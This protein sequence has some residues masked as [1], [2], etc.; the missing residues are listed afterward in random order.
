MRARLDDQP[1]N[2]PASGWEYVDDETIRLLPAGTP[3][4]QSHVYEFSLHRQGSAWWR[5]S[6]SP[7]RAISSRFLR[8]ALKDDAGNPNPLAGDVRH[9]FSFSIS[10]PS[11][12]L[13]DFQAF[14]FNEDEA[15]KT[16]HRRHAQ[17]DRRRQRRSNQLSVRADRQNRAEP[18]EPSVSGRCVPLRVSR[19]DRSSQRQ[20][21]GRI[22]RCRRATPARR[23]STPIPPTSTGSRPVRSCTPTRADSD[24]P[25]P[26]N[27]RFY[28][29]SGLSHGVGNVTSRGPCQQFLN[30]T[31]RSRTARATG[32]A[33]SVGRQRHRAAAESGAATEPTRRRSWR[34]LAP[35]IRP[36][37]CR[38]RR[39]AGRRF[40][41]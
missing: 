21:A 23:S 20:T 6:G 4:K 10:Q 15:G 27:V 24:L 16:R 28:L 33:R 39:W 3:F 9:T 19:A 22:A 36:A 32:G 1:A 29:I 31:A 30:P 38:R 35:A 5:G 34:C 13:N 17:V 26:D 12:T 40:R 25:D 41:A 37:S 8:H 18:A 14:G 7:P 11:R 2:V